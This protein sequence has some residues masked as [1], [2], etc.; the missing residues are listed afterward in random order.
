IEAMGGAIGLQSTE[1]AGSRFWIDVPVSTNHAGFAI[2]DTSAPEG[3]EYS[4]DPDANLSGRILYIEDNPA[5]LQ[6]VEGLVDRIPGLTMTSAA[7]G[8]DGLLAA[9]EFQPD[10]ILLDINLPGMDGYAVLRA[11]K[12]NPQTAA[13]PVIAMT[14]AATKDD[15]KR[16]EKGDF[17]A[18][19]TKPIQLTEV[20]A[21]I[22]KA[23]REA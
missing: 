9:R 23:I 19:I 5:N 1:G 8:E 11:L 17:F 7:N 12:E 2:E 3:A 13:T 20:L 10:V 21:T 18:Y 6:V 14:A 4:A 15:L 16:A 22:E